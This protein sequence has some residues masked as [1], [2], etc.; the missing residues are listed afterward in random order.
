MKQ[1]TLHSKKLL[2][3]LLVTAAISIV[4]VACGSDNSAGSEPD[5]P[6]AKDNPTDRIYEI[7]DLLDAGFKSLK[8]YDVEE[9]PGAISAN[10]GLYGADPNNKNEYEARFFS[11]HDEALAVGVDYV[12]EA[13]GPDA[14]LLKDTQRWDEGLRERRACAGGG[15]HQVGTCANA[16]Y[17]DYIVVGN[18]I[19]MCSGRD[20]AEALE[21]CAELMSVVK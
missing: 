9:L 21:A 4:A 6:I 16:K 13:T 11:S 12:K 5:G 20:S 3:L 8:S 19:L 7:Q 1:N 18:M 2:I 15:G 14:V 17:P 10:Y